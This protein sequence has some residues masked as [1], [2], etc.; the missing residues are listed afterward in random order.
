MA[1]HVAFQTGRIQEVLVTD[2]ALGRLSLSAFL[3][4]VFLSKD[5]LL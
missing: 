4:P 5:L 3:L 1:L 2:I